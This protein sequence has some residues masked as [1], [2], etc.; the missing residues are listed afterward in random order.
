MEKSDFMLND[1]IIKLFKLPNKKI[2][3][4]YKIFQKINGYYFNINQYNN[5]YFKFPPIDEW[6]SCYCD[7]DKTSWNN[8]IIKNNNI[9]YPTGFHS[10]ISLEDS[11]I[12]INNQPNY[13][14]CKCKIKY[15]LAE[16]LKSYEFESGIIQTKILVSRGLKIIKEIL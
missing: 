15:R 11:K 10:F 2:I 1:S 12:I 9:E 5:I 4:T 16:I 6:I 3:T 13:V 14:F 7:Y 8:I